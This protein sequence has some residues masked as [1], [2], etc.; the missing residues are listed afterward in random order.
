MKFAVVPAA[1]AGVVDSTLIPVMSRAAAPAEASSLAKNAIF[2][3]TL[4]PRGF[5]IR[6]QLSSS[7]LNNCQGTR[8]R[9]L[10]VLKGNLARKIV[11]IAA[12]FVTDASR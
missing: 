2:E 10:D 3:P 5:V 8:K 12:P 7:R 6:C 4:A 1:E 11:R 9:G